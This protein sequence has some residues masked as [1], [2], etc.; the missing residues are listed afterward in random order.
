MKTL[1]DISAYLRNA[2]SNSAYDYDEID[3]ELG[4]AAGTIV[5]ILDATGD[6][7]VMELMVVLNRFGLEL[8]IFDQIELKKIKEGPRG[9]SPELT[10]KTRV[11][12]AV[13]NIAQPKRSSN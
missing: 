7:S 4:L 6:Y 13:D 11:Q 2:L 12:I 8:D 9:P 10:V 5:R 3:A 1:D